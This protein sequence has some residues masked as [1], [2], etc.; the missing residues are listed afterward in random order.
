M[1]VWQGGR[2]GENYISQA[3]PG[4]K[5]FFRIEAYNS[6]RLHLPGGDQYEKANHHFLRA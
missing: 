3:T 5:N 2:L 6:V 4:N 1:R